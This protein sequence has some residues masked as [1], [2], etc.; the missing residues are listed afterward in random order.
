MIRSAASPTA[1]DRAIGP[2]FRPWL[3]LTGATGRRPPPLPPVAAAGRLLDG[4]APTDFGP[5]DLAPADLAP[6]DLVEDREPADEPSD[7]PADFVE[8]APADFAADREPADL[9][10]PRFT[11]ADRDDPEGF[12]PL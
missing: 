8:P 6:A 4:R 1:A 12:V 2:Q 11:A 10:A 3:T 9:V 5:A 7:E